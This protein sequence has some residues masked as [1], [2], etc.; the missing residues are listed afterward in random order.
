MPHPIDFDPSPVVSIDG[1]G[2]G[3]VG[4]EFHGVVKVRVSAIKGQALKTAPVRP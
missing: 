3:F 4:L 1:W 2:I